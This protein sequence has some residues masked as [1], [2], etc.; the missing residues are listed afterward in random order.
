ML[1]TP[2]DLNAPGPLRTVAHS[3]LSGAVGLLTW[4]AMFLACVGAVRGALY[5]LIA[6]ND[7]EHSWGGPGLAGAW[8]VHA[9][10]GIGLLPLWLL[11]TAAFGMIQLRLARRLLGRT[12]HWWPVPLA[13]ALILGGAA[14]FTA[15]WHQA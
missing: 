5:P 15:W 14:F 12:G 7:L 11:L 9:A 13:L 1:R 6:G 3:L 4:F 8:A 2:F 10:L